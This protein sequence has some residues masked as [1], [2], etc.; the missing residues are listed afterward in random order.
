MDIV[1]MI[2]MVDGIV[3]VNF[4]GMEQRVMNKQMGENKLL[5][6]AVY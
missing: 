3:N 4:G 6:S 2:L 5:H 1:R